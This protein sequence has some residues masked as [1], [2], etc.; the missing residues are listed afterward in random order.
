M[1]NPFFKVPTWLMWPRYI[2]QIDEALG[3]HEAWWTAF[4]NVSALVATNVTDV[5]RAESTLDTMSERAL[6]VRAWMMNVILPGASVP[7]LRQYLSVAAG[8]L[9]YRGDYEVMADAIFAF[10]GL[11]VEIV[12]PWQ[13]EELW[14]FGDGVFGDVELG[15]D[16]RDRPSDAWVF[17]DD[18]MEFGDGVF[19]DEGENLQRPFEVWVELYFDPGEAQVERLRA[20]AEFFLRAVDILVIKIPEANDCWMIGGVV[21]TNPELVERILLPDATAATD[22]ALTRGSVSEDGSRVGIDTFV[23]PAYLIIEEGVFGGGGIG[24]DEDDL[25]VERI[26]MPDGSA[27]PDE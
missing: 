6:L 13:I 1:T 17:G 2:R 25:V 27:E 22:T 7:L 16:F 19:G 20:V 14:T 12:V 23:C 10:T 24:P 26:L 5:T 21:E 3:Y 9:P 8:L 4:D 15:P 18:F 11:K